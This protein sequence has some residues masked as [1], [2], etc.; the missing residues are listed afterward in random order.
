TPSMSIL[1]W[2]RN[3]ANED[4]IRQNG[5]NGRRSPRPGPAPRYRPRLEALEDRWLPSTLTVMNT[6]DS[7]PGSL[8]AAIAASGSGDTIT[9]A[10]SLAGQT[11]T[12]TS[13][14][15]VIDHSLAILGAGG[16]NAVSISGNGASR[17]FDIS[18]GGATETLAHLRVVRGQ[19]SQGAG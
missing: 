7:G 5:V 6:A 11:I 16:E 18:A 2:L 12:L 8:R 17:V 13:G 1:H 15:L 4:A 3:R 9:F 10:G 19:A 14:E